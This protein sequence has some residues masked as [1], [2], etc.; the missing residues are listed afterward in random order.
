MSCTGIAPGEVPPDGLAAD[1]QLLYSGHG[2]HV[3]VVRPYVGEFDERR[4]CRTCLAVARGEPPNS[5]EAAEALPASEPV[6][7]ERP[8]AVH[9]HRSTEGEQ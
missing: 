2:T 6:L 9:L 8:A 4:A 3:P 1:V 7:P 5:P